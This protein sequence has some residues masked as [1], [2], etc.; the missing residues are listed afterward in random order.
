MKKVGLSSI[1]ATLLG[2]SMLFFSACSGDKPASKEEAKSE[3][4]VESPKVLT[5][6]NFRDIRDL[7]P[8][9]YAGE[10]YAQNMLFESLVHIDSEGKITPWLAQS[11]KI[12]EDGKTYTFKLREDVFFSDGEKFNAVAAKAN[13][14]AILAN[15][16]RHTWLESV[17]L[18]EAIDKAGGKSVEATSEYELTIRL[19]APYYPFLVEL[20]VIRP[21]RFVSPKAF[22]NGGTKEGVSAL[23]GTGAYIL[24]E[25]HKDQYAIFEANPKYWGEKPQS[26]QV[27]VKVIPDN[28]TRVMALEKGE[29]DLLFGTNMIDAEAYNRF[30]KMK[31]FGAAMSAPTSTRMLLINTADSVTGDLAIRKAIQHAT[32][33]ETIS[34]AIFSG[35]ESPADLTL[36]P[37]VPYA[38]LGLTPYEYN[39]A[40]AEAILEESGWKKVEGKKYREKEGKELAITLHYNSNNVVDKTIAEFVQGEWSKIGVNLKITGEEEQANRDRMKAGQFQIVFNI[41]WGTPYDPQSFLAGMRKPVYG[42]Y[43]AQLGIADKAAIDQNILEALE[44][45]SEEKRQEHYR[46]VLTRLHDEAVYLPLTYERN[47]AIFNE[48]VKNVGFGVSKYEVPFERMTLQ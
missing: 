29:V 14:D 15:A 17:R 46:F 37:S 38:N 3:A 26:K 24:K 6:A 19:D 43:F 9:L 2:A 42:D 18:M 32:N 10:L 22:I 21:F 39:L 48:K 4:K 25:N 16:P 5:F 23:S 27:V 40:K 7:N 11:W 45:T 12:S 34:K 33:K 8:H 13:F 28:Q 20:G 30:S 44:S 47:R 41:S 35:I 31:G 36:A 1:A